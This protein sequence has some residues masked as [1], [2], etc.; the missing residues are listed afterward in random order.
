MTTR[1]LLVVVSLVC[2]SVIAI[3]AQ[4]PST[5]PSVSD[6]Q[7]EGQRLFQQKCAVCHLAIVP[8]DGS[9]EPYARR[10]GKSLVDGNED[11]VRRMIADGTGPRMPG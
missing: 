5:E 3:A 8:A 7:Q 2:L 9:G 4:Q 1:G 6:P 11:D 10:L